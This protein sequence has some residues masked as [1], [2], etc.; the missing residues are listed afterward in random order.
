MVETVKSKN[1]IT[2]NIGTILIH[3]NIII[4]NINAT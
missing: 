2:I 4:G 3:K 1:I